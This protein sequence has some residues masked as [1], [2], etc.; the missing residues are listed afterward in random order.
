MI[1]PEDENF[2]L[3]FRREAPLDN[4]VDFMKV[5][6][7]V[8]LRSVSNTCNYNF[9]NTFFNEGLWVNVSK[10]DIYTQNV[11]QLWSFFL[12]HAKTST[13]L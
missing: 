12:F 10:L 3:V 8:T 5:R 9:Y 13:V 11:K 1:L 6:P 7:D 4:S 2:L